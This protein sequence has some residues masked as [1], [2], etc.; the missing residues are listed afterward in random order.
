MNEQDHVQYLSTTPTI[1]YQIEENK[2]NN[3]SPFLS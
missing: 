3:T 1:Q 2:L